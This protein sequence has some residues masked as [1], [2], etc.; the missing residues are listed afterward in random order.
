MLVVGSR[1]VGR[2][3]LVSETPREDALGWLVA[4]P[5]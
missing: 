2:P 3:R 1:R 5:A 4:E